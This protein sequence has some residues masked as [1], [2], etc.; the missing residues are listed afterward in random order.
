MKNNL[1]EYKLKLK[2]DYLTEFESIEQYIACSDSMYAKKEECLEEILDLLLTAQEN[3]RVPGEVI[4]KDIKTFC[5][6]I[7]KGINY[8]SFVFY[9]ALRLVGISATALFMSMFFMVSYNVFGIHG[10]IVVGSQISIIY[11]FG[12][13]VSTVV[14]DFFIDYYFRKQ[15]A[16]SGKNKYAKYKGKIRLILVMLSSV[17]FALIQGM[18][19]HKTYT[20]I[21]RMLLIFVIALLLVA[22]IDCIERRG[23]LG[24]LYG[25][26]YSKSKN[27]G[28]LKTGL[29]MKY[30]KKKAKNIRKNRDYSVELFSKIQ[31]KEI[32]ISHIL[33]CILLPVIIGDVCLC[34]YSI[35]TK[36]LGAGIFVLFIFILA[37]M[38]I[39]I[40]F[41]LL[42]KPQLKLLQDFYEENIDN[43]NKIKMV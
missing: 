15:I 6:N 18:D 19:F 26:T 30:E 8:H 28:I 9:M 12:I 4:G 42:K 17:L 14:L 35:L 31:K 33:F 5:N 39:N 25:S 38:V 41:I 1:I 2:S 24:D 36:E 23:G 43:E 34:S 20:T 27:I 13:A 21:P 10:T 32:E 11:A 29:Y 16:K 37:L 40:I 3:G 22:V 7:L